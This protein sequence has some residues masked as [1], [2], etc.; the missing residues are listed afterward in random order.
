MGVEQQDSV[1]GEARPPVVTVSMLGSLSSRPFRELTVTWY[2]LPGT[3]LASRA[4][5]TAPSTVSITGL[6][7]GERQQLGVVSFIA[8]L[9]GNASY[10]LQRARR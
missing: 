7:V 6:P 5:N 8:H 2:F 10:L 3:M 1:R 9:S 4:S